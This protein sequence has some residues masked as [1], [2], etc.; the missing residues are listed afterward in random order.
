VLFEKADLLKCELDDFVYS[1]EDV[2]I[3]EILQE[4]SISVRKL[5]KYD[6][7]HGDNGDKLDATLIYDISDSGKFDKIYAELTKNNTNA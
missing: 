5:D 3:A 2:R 1:F 7:G 4:N 6:V